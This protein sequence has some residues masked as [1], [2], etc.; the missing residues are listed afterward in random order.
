VEARATRKESRRPVDPLKGKITAGKFEDRGFG[1]RIRQRPVV[2][3][4]GKI[5]AGG[6][7]KKKTR[8]KGKT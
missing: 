3:T 2:S 1:R 6:A 5:R 8:E 4:E 7:K